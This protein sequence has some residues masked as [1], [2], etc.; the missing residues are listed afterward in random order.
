MYEFFSKDYLLGRY[1]AI[2]YFGNLD[3]FIMDYGNKNNVQIL[4]I[5]S[6]KILQK[7]NLSP[8]ICLDEISR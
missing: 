7:L 5:L 1:G 8:Y 2:P 3:K 6:A 4:Q